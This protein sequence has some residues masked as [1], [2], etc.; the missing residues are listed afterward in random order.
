MKAAMRK[1]W[2]RL[3]GGGRGLTALEAVIALALGVFVLGA[4]V[5]FFTRESGV[6][7]DENDQT[8]VRAKARHAIKLIAREVRMAGYGLAPGQAIFGFAET[9]GA[10]LT[11]ITPSDPLPAQAAA[12]G[13]RI[14]RENVRTFFDY[15]ST[16]MISGSILPVVDGSGFKSGDN[17][18]IYNPSDNTT[19]D[20]ALTTV[21]SASAGS[22]TLQTALNHSY[23]SDPTSRV[24]QVAKY[25]NVEIG[26]D[27]QG[28]ITKVVDGTPSVLIDGA[29][30]GPD[31]G[32]A[33]DFHGSASARMVEL[34]G[35]HLSVA[36]PDN[37]GASID[38]KTDVRLRNA[39]S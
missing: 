37:P 21:T 23:P 16:T 14:N 29:T 28:H 25:N 35:I 4:V 17:V 10:A 8:L 27:N 12:I 24:I 31:L 18:A 13:F 15:S 11:N 9:A 3:D 5:S 39:T 6:L 7:K 32:L 26:I 30:L 2:K 36:D 22:L 38:I 19:W 34:V 20:E 1:T 33:F